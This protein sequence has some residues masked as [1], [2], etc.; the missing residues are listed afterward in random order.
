[1]TDQT[2]QDRVHQAVN[3]G[4]ELVAER[5]VAIAAVQSAKQDEDRVRLDTTVDV[6]TKQAAAERDAEIRQVEDDYR[7]T[8]APVE[9][10]W[11]RAQQEYNAILTERNQI[12]AEGIQAAN[13]QY[14]SITEAAKQEQ[15]MQMATARATVY[16]AEREVGA[17][18]ATIDQHKRQ[19]QESIGIDLS[20]LV[21]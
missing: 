1:M 21:V 19:V 8:L 10:E 18:Q 2:I 11:K 6:V 15:K 12:K 5:M 17:I 20:P 7:A 4:Y 16:R 14:A 9:A 3:R 13:T